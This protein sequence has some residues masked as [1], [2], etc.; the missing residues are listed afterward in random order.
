MYGKC[1]M[2]E[3]ISYG[4]KNYFPIAVFQYNKSLLSMAYDVEL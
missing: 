3:K 2:N 1:T 4:Q